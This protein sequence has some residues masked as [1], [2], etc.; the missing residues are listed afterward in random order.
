MKIKI[1]KEGDLW[2]GRA[3][4]MKKAMCFR[5]TNVGV[6]VNPCCDSCALFGEPRFL[7]SGKTI[8][9]THCAGNVWYCD[10]NDFTDERVPVVLEVKEEYLTPD[11]KG[12]R[13]KEN[14]K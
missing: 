1:D 11:I 8:E 13:G 5:Q 14:G 4:V 6:G 10:C 3:G 12:E 7:P 9:I 2:L